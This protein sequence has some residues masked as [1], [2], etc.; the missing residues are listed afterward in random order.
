MAGPELLTVERLITQAGAHH[1]EVKNRLD[2]GL[3]LLSCVGEL[4]RQ[5]P[6]DMRQ[7]L[8]QVLY[9]AMLVDTG[10]DGATFVAGVEAKPEFEALIS[11]A[12]G[13]VSRVGG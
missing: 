3:Q 12:D 13:V 1:E 7:T 5:C 10:S 11:F 9:D 6:D 4:Y 8:N 2:A